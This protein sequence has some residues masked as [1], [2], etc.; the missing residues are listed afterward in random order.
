M[1]KYQRIKQIGEGA[2]GKAILVKKKDSA[3]Q[4]VIKE[5]NI[6]KMSVKE[7]E[8]SRKEVAVL[9][10]LK[11]P[12]I[13]SYIE[14]FEEKGSLYIVMNYCSGGDMYGKI[15]ERRG[16]L[17][18]EDQ[19]L[20]W[21]VQLCLAIKHIHDRK[22]LH[23]D[24][25]SQNIFLTN[26]GTV[27]LGDFGIAKVLNTT[28]QLAHT[29]IGTPYYLSPEIV[30]NMPYNNKS[31]IWSM[32]CVLYELTTLKHAFE[33]PNMKNL[34]L[35]IIRGSYLPLPPQYSYDLR[36]LIAQMF[37][38]NPRDRP[39]V[40]TIL[41]KNFIM[42]RVRKFLSDQDM[43]EEFSHTV[44]HGH[45]IAKALPPA[46]KPSADPSKK[47][48]STPRPGSA[49][50]KYDPA[51]VYGAPLNS[52]KNR[53]SG[54]KK[55][56]ST[57]GRQAPI[58]GQVDWD[59]KRKERQELE[60]KR[61]AE[62][63][64]REQDMFERKQKELMD[65][66]KIQRMNKAREE[67]WK[68]LI[69]PH[70]IDEN[71]AQTPKDNR[72]KSPRPL[73]VPKVNNENRNRGDYQAYNQF[74][75]KLYPD[76]PPAAAVRNMNHVEVVY[77]AAP[78]PLPA[79][80]QP[81]LAAGPQFNM[82][83]LGVPA[84]IDQAGRDRYSYNMQFGAQAAHRARLVEDFLYN[85]QLAQINKARAQNDLY[86]YRPPSAQRYSPVPA[87][88]RGPSPGPGRGN[89]GG[90]R[91]GASN[92]RE[93][94]EQAYLEKLRQIRE[95][96]FKDRRAIQGVNEPPNA[97]RNKDSE[98]TE[99]RKKKVEAL[100]LQAE[101]W[102]EMRKNRPDSALPQAATPVAMTG[103]LQAIGAIDPKQAANQGGAQE[104]VVPLTNAL[105][106]VG[107]SSESDRPQSAH[108]KKKD[109]I[110]K[111]LNNK[112][113]PSRSK[114]K[115]PASPAVAEDVERKQWG[116]PVSPAVNLEELEA[117]KPHWGSG[118][119]LHLSNVPLEM[120][121]SLME[122]TTAADQVVR[123]DAAGDKEK[124]RGRWGKQPDVVKA[125]DQMP[126]SQDTLTGN[127]S[128]KVSSPTLPGPPAGVGVT[129]T[130]T[131][132]PVSGPPNIEGGT[133]E[134][135]QTI[136]KRPLPPPPIRS[137]TMVISRGTTDKNIP[138]VDEADSGKKLT[139]AKGDKSVESM[140]ELR[141]DAK[142]VQLK[143]TSGNFDLK[144]EQVKLLRTISEPN[145][146][147][148]FTAL[149]VVNTSAPSTPS[150]LNQTASRRHHS[151]DLTI[152][153]EDDDIDE[154][155]K[156]IV[157]EDDFAE[158]D[159]ILENND[160][161]DEDFTRMLESMQTFI[162]DDDDDDAN[163]ENLDQTKVNE[164]KAKPDLQKSQSEKE[165]DD[166]A[167][168]G[169]DEGDSNEDEDETPKLD[170]MSLQAVLNLEDSDDD[171]NFGDEDDKDYDR[172]GH[173]EQM[174][175]ELMDLLGADKL[176]VV[177]AVAQKSMEDDNVQ[178]EDA[179][180]EALNLMGSKASETLFAKI[181][182]LALADTAYTEDDQ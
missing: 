174:R 54:E 84:A 82:G 120:T 77:M 126:V 118:K 166:N 157:E 106:V 121:A 153:P 139:V 47:P 135:K 144:R 114:W 46:P 136:T 42:Q 41:R 50:K 60:E 64:K 156:P 43:Q 66:Q 130:I 108:Q 160:G 30:E 159:I 141:N 71:R 169:D 138:V 155:D 142:S 63:K 58:P 13:V 27:Q 175:K 102:A 52:S 4:Y 16:Q 124:S 62:M 1:N 76:R 5:I 145:L 116:P 182:K 14:S 89:V 15:N 98:S 173:L 180:K 65:K 44:M 100:K 107:G 119:D 181:F 147:S 7:R 33:A 150:S 74:L 38:R 70:S 8:E 128:A 165:P 32:G 131:Q 19:I 25:K 167:D 79:A 105:N 91:G 26:T 99:E 6:I 162:D 49:N 164:V 86:G 36:G 11:H 51:A 68:Q 2:F 45:K 23:R 123:M 172:F 83:P 72:P 127:D 96:N 24:I 151:L 177:Y 134:G 17:F 117:S 9:S 111:R 67:G 148:L 3:R 48:N 101:H 34:V 80:Q 29:C 28:A 152:V 140:D 59:K 40:N 170:N 57:P 61:R 109:G 112:Q 69:D 143:M 163:N 149:D 12:N 90:G 129:I 161:E 168:D 178:L 88:R 133:S 132:K 171:I 110:L 20:D 176:R 92:S 154:V 21:F 73:P 94:E 104:P 122:A 55:R 85:K 97:N 158:E 81:K 10:Q 78:R 39:S 35:K 37:K 103:A 137:G 31:D 115:A 113:N 87:P 75:D 18:S 95:Q 53:M 146:T 125:L 22:I 179:T 56:P 93:R